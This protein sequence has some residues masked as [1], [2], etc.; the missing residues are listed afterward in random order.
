MA[1]QATSPACFEAPSFDVK[2]GD[3]GYFTSGA[4]QILKQRGCVHLTR[5]RSGHTG[6]PGGQGGGPGTCTDIAPMHNTE[7][8]TGD[9]AAA[10]PD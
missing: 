10:P 5:G 4:L 2:G 3:S 9:T 8:S 1:A 7:T 6:G